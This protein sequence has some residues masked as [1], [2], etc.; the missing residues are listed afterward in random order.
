MHDMAHHAHHAMPMISAGPGMM[1]ALFLA[2]LVGSVSHCIG[3]CGPFALAL[4]AGPSASGPRRVA[5]LL[6]YHVGKASAY[7]VLGVVAAV[8]MA[9]LRDLPIFR[10][11]AAAFLFLAGGLFL[12]MAFKALPI[13]FLSC[14]LP[15]GLL[16]FAQPLFRAENIWGRYL[17]GLMLGFIP[18]GLV[19]GAL[20]AV[21]A[22]GSPL[23]AVIGMGSFAAGTVPSLLAVS[24]CGHLVWRR[25]R[26]HPWMGKLASVCLVF[27]SFSLFVFAAR[28]II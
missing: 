27:S 5:G 26:D 4:T 15:A 19:Y 13:R 16:A 6:A 28:W 1:G 17:L 18:C 12:A 14:H 22:T 20:L 3:M 10:Y 7:M 25:W 2:A 11:L 23:D 9:T 21:A 24:L 8:L